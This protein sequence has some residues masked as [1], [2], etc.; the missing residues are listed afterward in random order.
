MGN[1]NGKM[2]FFRVA[3]V[4]TIKVDCHFINRIGFTT[5][6]QTNKKKK[7]FK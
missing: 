7:K 6:K 4:A 1:I 2:F 5:N 3:L